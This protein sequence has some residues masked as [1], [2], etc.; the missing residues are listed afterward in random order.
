MISIPM[1]SQVKLLSTALLAC[2]LATPVYADEEGGG[3]ADGMQV[4]ITRNLESVTINHDGREVVVQRNQDTKNVVDPGFAKTSRKCPPFCV[5]PIKLAEGVETLGTAE[6]LD[7]LK[8]KS[9]GD[10]TIEVI[11]SRGID[12][13]K[14]GT[15]PGTINIHYKKLSLKSGDPD[16]I[17][18]FMEETFG[19]QRRGEFWD[20]S[21][22]KTL[23]LFCNGMWCGQAPTNIKTLLRLG[24][25]AE[26]LKWYRGGMQVW[27]ILG[28][29]TVKPTE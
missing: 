26:K 22:A 21:Y 15:I 14:R 28:L 9:D 20:Y 11:D 18:D 10:D 25:P 12:W 8:R 16:E 29:N 5:Q 1:P 24:Y 4:K 2:L 19:V 23:V 27:Q 7:Y 3:S 13:V 6:M 17:V